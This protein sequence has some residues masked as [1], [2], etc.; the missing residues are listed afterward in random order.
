MSQSMQ[1]TRDQSP[2]VKAEQLAVTYQLGTPQQEYGVQL[3]RMT[4][5]SGIASL[6]LAGG[7]G[8]FAY[9]MLTSPRNSNDI[10]NAFF[11][12][13]VGVVFLLGALYC[14]L[15]PLIY[16]SWRV[17]VGSEG[18]AFSRGSKLDAFRWDQIESMWQRVT[19]RYM[20]GIYIGTQHKYTVRGLDGRQVVLNDRITHVE[21]LGNVISD[22][23]TRVKLPEAITAFKA[24]STLT[25]GPLS[26]SMQGVSNRKELISWD[27]IKEFKVNN[28]IVTVKKEGK[29]LSWSSV[30]AANIPNFFIFL[31]LVNAIMR[32][33]I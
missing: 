9:E 28:G 23:V 17:Y 7:F 1:V 30:Q 29:W 24:G 2:S 25:F 13:G 11:V 5:F 26:V 16:R 33:A 32:K 18:F 3:T 19:R 15:Y 12:I 22:M 31:A 27:Q 20:N 21:R 8:F 10:N 4:L 14:F 6:V